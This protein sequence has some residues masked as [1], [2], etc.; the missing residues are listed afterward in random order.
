MKRGSPRF[1]N[2][3]YGVLALLICVFA[4]ILSLILLVSGEDP[5]TRWTSFLVPHGL[6]LLFVSLV[7]SV[8]HLVLIRRPGYTH[9]GKLLSVVTIIVIILYILFLSITSTW[10]PF[11]GEGCYFEEKYSVEEC[12]KT[13]EY[14]CRSYNYC[15]FGKCN[16]C[17]EIICSG[18]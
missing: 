17:F 9:K 8:I 10:G 4:V 16:V 2:I 15:G 14:S 13:E 6:L 18:G 11:V 5:V 3:N 1:R 7:A 12:E